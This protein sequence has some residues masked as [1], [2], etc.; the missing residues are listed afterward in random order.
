MPL[1]RFTTTIIDVNGDE[2]VKYRDSLLPSN[3]DRNFYIE[4]LEDGYWEVI[5]EA[6]LMTTDYEELDYGP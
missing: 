5:D 6:F 3:F 4:R 1:Y 2:T